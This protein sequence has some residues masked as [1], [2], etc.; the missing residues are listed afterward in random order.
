M[1][2]LIC[3]VILLSLIC[4]PINVFGLSESNMHRQ[5]SEM[6]GEFDYLKYYS[7]GKYEQYF[8]H[9]LAYFNYSG[10]LEDQPE[11][12]YILYDYGYKEIYEYF[13]DGSLIDSGAS[14]SEATPDYVLIT[15]SEVPVKE[16]KI[17]VE[18]YGDYVVKTD[19][20]NKAIYHPYADGNGYYIIIPGDDLH[21]RNER[22]VYVLRD[23]Y[24]EGI[25]GIEAVFEKYGLGYLI[26]DTNNDRALNVKDATYIQKCLAGL[27]EF[28]SYDCL[29]SEDYEPQPDVP[30]YV[31]DFNRDGQRNIKDATAIQ[32]HIAGLF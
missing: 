11:P 25:K 23:A 30:H 31:T 28:A 32:K 6:E 20:T 9:Y 12:I 24:D 18:I 3:F 26:G 21:Y 1:K 16:D 14:I 4:L 8:T 19:Q 29:F 13:S 17:C 27:E 10:Y 15:G 7:G 2:R 5:N 22:E